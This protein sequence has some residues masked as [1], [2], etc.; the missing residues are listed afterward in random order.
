MLLFA[1]LLFLFLLFSDFEQDHNAQY[2]H[3]PITAASY[4][5]CVLLADTMAYL[6]ELHNNTAVNKKLCYVVLVFT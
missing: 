1:V 6:Q 3:N 4:S 2:Y 5:L